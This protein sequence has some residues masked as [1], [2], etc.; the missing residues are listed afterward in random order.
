MKRM[1]VIIGVCILALTVATMGLAAT[2]NKVFTEGKFG[3]YCTDPVS[4]V[5]AGYQVGIWGTNVPFKAQAVDAN[6]YLVEG[7]FTYL[8]DTGESGFMDLIDTGIY[9]K[10]PYVPD[11]KHYAYDVS[12]DS[13]TASGVVYRDPAQCDSC[14]ATPPGHIADPATWGQCKSCHD[15]GVQIHTHAATT[16]NV[17]PDNCYACHPTGCYDTDVHKD[18]A[19]NLWCTDCHGT[20]SDV[21]TGDFKISGQAGK[22]LCGDCHDRNHQESKKG[23]LF[24]DAN[25]HG[26]ML[27]ISCH[28]SPHRVEK[29]VNLGDGVNNNCSGCHT[30]Q[31]SDPKMGMDCGACHKSSWDPHLVNRA[32]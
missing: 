23:G 30:T 8:M 15:L 26:G 5:N 29:P 22:P 27:C 16:A 13:A 2:A 25:K 19:I 21:L 31:G 11:G 12:V 24:A 18:P 9:Q 7:S 10:A 32:K 1:L 6:G 4:W 28:N 14:H 17:A 20:L 3:E